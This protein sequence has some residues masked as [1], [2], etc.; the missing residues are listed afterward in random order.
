ME[1]WEIEYRE[2]LSKDGNLGK[3]LNRISTHGVF[4]I[5]LG[6]RSAIEFLVELRKV[7]RQMEAEGKIKYRKND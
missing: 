2:Y 7:A 3:E 5:V 4:P 1:Q 6:T